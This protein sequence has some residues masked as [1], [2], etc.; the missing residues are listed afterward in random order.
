MNVRGYAAI[1]VCPSTNDRGHAP[2]SAYPPTNVRRHAIISACPPTNVSG[3]AI[4]FACPSTNVRRHAAIFTCPPMNVSG[5]TPI[6]ACP[7]MNARGHTTTAAYPLRYVGGH[8]TIRNRV[9]HF[10]IRVY[11]DSESQVQSRI[12]YPLRK[13][14]FCRPTEYLIQSRK[15]SVGRH[16]ALCWRSKYSDVRQST[17]SKCGNTL[18]AVMMLYPTEA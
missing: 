10:R 9:L 18:T 13:I 6:V 15:Y 4:I 14:A 3:H 2:S 17:L 1:F 7:S 8:A 11:Y 16:D 12:F 5:H